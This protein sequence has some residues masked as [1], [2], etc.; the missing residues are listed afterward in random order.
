MYVAVIYASLNFDP[1]PRSNFDRWC[2]E[3]RKLD[4]LENNNKKSLSLIRVSLNSLTIAEQ[5][6]LKD[7]YKEE[8][9]DKYAERKPR[10]LHV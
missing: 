8:P 9:N 4:R 7:D 1:K 10:S 5:L 3:E 2:C 6:D